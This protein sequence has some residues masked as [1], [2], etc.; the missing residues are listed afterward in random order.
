VNVDNGVT[1]VIYFA[2]IE[3]NA[4]MLATV[5]YLGYPHVRL[6]VSRADSL[7]RCTPTLQTGC[8]ADRGWASGARPIALRASL[9]VRLAGRVFRPL[10]R[11]HVDPDFPAYELPEELQ[12]QIRQVLP[13]EHYVAIL[14]ADGKNLT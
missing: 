3:N 13:Q 1:C 11:R 8:D 2:G 5:V 9:L 4:Y 12:V 6:C 14:T 7:A 10:G